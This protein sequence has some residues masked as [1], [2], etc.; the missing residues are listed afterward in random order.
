MSVERKADIQTQHTIKDDACGLASDAC[1]LGERFDR[2]LDIALALDEVTRPILNIVG[3]GAVVRDT[4]KERYHAVAISRERGLRCGV[5]C[6]EPVNN[7]V[8]C[9]VRGIAREYNGD[10]DCIRV[11][12]FLQ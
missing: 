2:G 1:N 7:T 8:D 5:D 12:G 3:L 11:L 6:K 9:R 10:T 4:W